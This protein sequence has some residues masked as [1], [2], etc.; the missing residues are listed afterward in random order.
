MQAL[1]LHGTRDIRVEDV[2]EPDGHLAPNQVL[3]RNRRAGICGTDLHEYLD[4]PMLAT[5]TPHALTGASVPQILGH[6]YSG[7]VLAIGDAV[8]TVVPGDRVAIMPLFFCGAC[9]PCRGGSPH[10]C[11][12]LGAVGLNWSWGGM[13]EQSVVAEHQVA[14]LP[15]E[16][17]DL[18]GAMVEPAAVAVNA[19]TKAGVRLGDV[20][21]VTGAGPIGQLVALAAGAAGAGAVYLSE[22]NPRRRARAQKLGLTGV[23][24]PAELD[25]PSFI[26]TASATGADVAIE[27]TGNAMA[28]SACLQTLRPGAT[29]M[30][31]GLHVRPADVDL[32]SVT[33]RDV[34]L[35]G[36]N[37][38]PVDSWP[39]VIRLIAAGALPVDRTLTAEVPLADGL[40]AFDALLDPEGDQIKVVLAV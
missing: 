15:D 8:R 26:R 17:S 31:T 11:E 36:A 13:G 29:L 25:V 23:L 18:Q 40:D 21:L 2:P 14:V 33:L 28:M 7:E 6:E 37:C 16:L 12:R 30:Q 24:D 19:V 1:R 3:L 39:R 9:G 34:T 27:C 10:V 22:V 32:R 20:V 4:G 5:T 38:F 35:R